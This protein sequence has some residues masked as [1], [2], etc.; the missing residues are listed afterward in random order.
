MYLIYVSVDG[1]A[2]TIPSALLILFTGADA[3]PWNVAEPHRR[4]QETCADLERRNV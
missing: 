1:K 3:I 2:T 4:D